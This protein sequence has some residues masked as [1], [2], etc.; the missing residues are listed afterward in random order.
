MS[1][2]GSIFRDGLAG[3]YQTSSRNW[4]DTFSCNCVGPRNGE[5]RCP[6]QMRNVIERDGRW[7]VPEQ[8]LGPVRRLTPT[9]PNRSE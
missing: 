6:C 4:L 7:V 5:P 9:K 1:S 2:K 3:T 8:D